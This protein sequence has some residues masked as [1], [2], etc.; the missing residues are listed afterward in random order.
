MQLN[1]L[2]DT[3][4][5]H[6]LKQEFN[7]ARACYE[8]ILQHVPDNPI[9]LHNH[10]L[11]CTQLG[12]YLAAIESFNKAVDHRYTESYISRG[13]VHRTLGNYHQAMVDFGTAFMLSPRH[14]SAYSNYGNTLREFG[15]PDV[16]LPFLKIA[17]DI[18][19][20]VPT[21]RLNES[22]AHLLK[23][24][25]LSGWEKYDARWFFDSKA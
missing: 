6:Y 17:Q 15:M 8:T 19:P 21:F 16:A 9:V 22:I 14:A 13:A 7:E 18:D 1:D 23:G 10:G 11:A 2:F 4:N 5:E 24:D 20:N 12:D 25:L 3:G